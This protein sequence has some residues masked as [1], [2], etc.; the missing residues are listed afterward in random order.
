MPNDDDGVG[1]GKPPKH[2]QFTKGR[3][4]NPRGRAKGSKNLSTT[5]TNILN[6]RVTITQGGEKKIVLLSDALVLQLVNG[7]LA[8]NP[9]LIQLLWQHDYLDEPEPLVLWISE[10]D[11]RL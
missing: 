1:Y 4:G 2:H 9:R 3:S 10:T 5:L 6:R 8:G 7:A 11:S